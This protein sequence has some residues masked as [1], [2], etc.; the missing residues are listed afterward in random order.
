MRFLSL[1]LIVSLIFSCKRIEVK[2]EGKKEIRM[3]KIVYKKREFREPILRV[4]LKEGRGDFYISA[5]SKY[6]VI[7]KNKRYFAY[8]GDFLKCRFVSFDE[9][10]ISYKGK[11]FL[12]ETPILFEAEGGFILFEN[13]RYRGKILLERGE[14]VINIVKLEDYLFGVIPAEIGRKD[15]SLVEAFKAQAVCARSYALRKYFERKDAPFHLYADVKDQVYLGRDYEDAWGNSA[16]ETTRGVVC[17]YKDEIALTL[18]HSTCGGVTANFKDMFPAMDELPYL[19]NVRCNLYGKD[20]CKVS[21]YYSWERK[22]KREDFENLI[23]NNFFKIFGINLNGNIFKKMDIKKSREGR[24]IE[25]KIEHEKGNIILKPNEIRILFGDCVKN[26]P[27][28]S[29]WF[30]LIQR[31]DEILLK[32]RGF[33]HGIGLCQYGA[34]ELSKMGWN[35]EKIIQLYFP[36]TKIKK[37]YN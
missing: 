19:R 21:P 7:S 12:F 35:Y 8:A 24:I 26:I 33:G 31:G 9:V 15:P 5:T 13:K 36:G 2:P 6:T 30:D 32:G 1:F 34:R 37:L 25:M 16:C 3:K 4:L 17:V 29:V 22:Y 10:L 28:P 14:K 11:D 23:K 27:L 18:Y 20:L